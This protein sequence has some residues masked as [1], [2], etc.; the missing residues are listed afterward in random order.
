MIYCLLLSATGGACAACLQPGT[1]AAGSI[2]QSTLNACL[3][4]GAYF[5]AIGARLNRERRYAEAADALE[6]SL[7]L[8]PDNL[9][10]AIEYAIALSGIG[11]IRSSL[12]LL[13]DLLANPLLPG[14]LRT[15]LE[16]ERR[17][18]ASGEWT[19]RALV[20]VRF[21]RD[22]NLLG[23]PNLSSL[24]LTTSAGVLQLPL[25][26]AYR[27]RSS[28][29]SRFDLEAEARREAPDGEQLN[30]YASMHRRHSP[31]LSLADY[32]Q[33]AAVAEYSDHKAAAGPYANL[34]AS[35]FR[36]FNGVLY[37]VAAFAVGAGAP[38]A[39]H[40]VGR[41]GGSVETRGYPVNTLLDSRYAGVTAAVSC[42]RPLAWTANFR[43]GRES[44][45]EDARPG[46][47]QA[48]A[49]VRL[50]ALYP[51][52]SGVLVG[53]GQSGYYRD[54]RGY[55]PLL[56]NGKVRALRRQTA[57]VEYR[58]PIG[59]HGHIALGGEWVD[60]QASLDLFRFRSRGAYLATRL[61]W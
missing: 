18:A 35:Q 15:T 26:E 1:V 30:F 48:Q 20:G 41:L 59:T 6:R 42:P 28:G 14:D 52:G 53:D 60:Q 55:S 57:V 25:T 54:A 9:D 10:A 46:G 12:A 37:K 61:A 22:S 44:A 51:V 24:A 56:E 45:R 4:D 2:E 33:Y 50:S 49:E 21:G 17:I 29:F 40:C 23:A 3:K 8:T 43:I 31:G 32:Q 58:Y 19:Q 34:A 36:S 13:G 5:A 27:A 16:A 11:D 38:V 39:G 47:D 7:M